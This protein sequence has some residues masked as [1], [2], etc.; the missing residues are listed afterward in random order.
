MIVDI[1]VSK[2]RATFATPTISTL[3]YGSYNLVNRLSRV[4][5]KQLTIVNMGV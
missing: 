4:P 5:T 3:F 2:Y 1:I